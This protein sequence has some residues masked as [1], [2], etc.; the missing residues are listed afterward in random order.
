MN[1]ESKNDSF[2]NKCKKLFLECHTMVYNL[3]DLTENGLDELMNIQNYN[4]TMDI[5]IPKCINTNMHI[6]FSEPNILQEASNNYRT[7][8]INKI[9]SKIK[10]YQKLITYQMLN[11]NKQVYIENAKKLF[12][13]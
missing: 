6:L 2:D 10:E 11:K 5:V 8:I 7:K 3:Y 9:I 12:Y 1:S 13:P 4:K